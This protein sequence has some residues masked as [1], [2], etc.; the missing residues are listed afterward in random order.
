[1]SQGEQRRLA[2][3]EVLFR[4]ANEAIERGQWP[5]DPEKLVRFRCECARLDCNDAVELTLGEYE[6]IRAFPR[7]FV[8]VAGHEQPEIESVISRRDGHVVV[9]KEQAAGELAAATDPRA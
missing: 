2:R 1:M 9:E 8:L 7:R 4:D 6:R 3:N 5:D